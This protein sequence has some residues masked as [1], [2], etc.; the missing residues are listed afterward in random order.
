[1]SNS[2]WPRG[3]QH[4]RLPCPSLSSRVCSNSCPL[5]Q[6][7]HPTISFSVSPFSFCPQSFP[8][9]GSFPVA[10]WGGGIVIPILQLRK[11]RHWSQS[12]AQGHAANK[13]QSQGSNPCTR[14][15]APILNCRRASHSQLSCGLL[16]SPKRVFLA[17]SLTTYCKRGLSSSTQTLVEALWKRVAW[18]GKLAG[19]FGEENW[20]VTWMPQT[21]KP[22]YVWKSSTSSY[23]VNWLKPQRWGMGRECKVCVSAGPSAF[24]LCLVL[25]GLV[26]DWAGQRMGS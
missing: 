22:I 13:R 7:C 14:P 12:P 1:M 9:S 23:P 16:F 5:N 2:L 11:L 15:R 18:V 21:L 24:S 20:G 25:F 8:A 10:L 4:A 19:M 6:W 3:L 26:F 17:L